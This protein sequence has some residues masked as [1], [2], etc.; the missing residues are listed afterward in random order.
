MVDS[1]E[2]VSGQSMDIEN[3]D[4]EKFRAAF[5]Q[6][7]SEGKIDI[8][9]LLALFGQYDDNDFE[10]YKFEW[11]G[12][13]ECYRI[14][15]KRSTGTIRPY[16]NESVNFDTT[17]N[18]YIEGDNLEVLK[19]LQASY[20]RKVKM[21]YIDPPY[22][23]GNDFVYEDDF[24][25]PMAKY[26]EVTQQTTKSNPETMGR[27]HTNWLNMM[28]PRLRLA[29]NLLR[30]D[31]VIFISIDETE[32]HNLKKICDE[33]FGEENFIADFVWHNKRGG[34]ND[35][36]FVAVEHE[37]VILYAKNVNELSELFVPYSPQYMLRYKE[38]DE[39][40]KFFWDTFKRKSGKQYYPITCPDGTVLQYDELG[41][42][43]SWLRS[44]PR[45]KEDLAKGEIRI[46]K[47]K[48]NW[49]V[50]FKQRLPE[51]K[52]PRTIFLEESI[53]EKQGTTADGSA[54]TLELFCKNVF[55]NPKPIGLIKH[56]LSFNTEDDDIIID[57][58][59]GSG[60]TAHAVMQL[61]SE[62]NQNRRFILVQLPA[63]I[64][65]DNKNS[66][67]AQT[68]Y[69]FLVEQGMKNNLCEIS[70]ERIRRA[71]TNIHEQNDSVDTGF[72]VFKLDTSNLVKW[73]STPTEDA[74]EL[75]QRMALLKETIKPDRN[76]LDMVY[77]TMLKLGIPLDY[78]VTEVEVNDKKAYSIGEDCLVLICLDYG[79]D[80]ITAEDIKTMCDDYVP[81]K[82]VASEQ[83]FKD[84]VA[85]SNA[86]Y[87]LKDRQI[88]MKLL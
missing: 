32:L 14:A 88:E 68:A 52:K 72:K 17:K 45:F 15:G 40:G 43:I 58:F 70:K 63:L 76:D 71:G 30:D 66:K 6:C 74:E 7:F 53:F 62:D 3:A 51:G 60:T 55:D 85:L 18:M 47:I 12:K 86:H 31:G 87:I 42:P 57:F 34:G 13:S 20:Y 59:A 26:K 19:L 44:E 67:T 64:E 23:T 77:E 41:N 16:P 61:N 8:S 24:S 48:D 73:D 39:L 80:G 69:E 36:K 25:D 29:A 28:Y 1:I 5:P 10:K 4:L 56:I 38:E 37:Y 2:R 83:A 33:V 65:P 82:I 35:A 54:E 81:A 79:K 84:D 49:S 50:Q 75:T 78:K 9:K 27:Y 46:V 11:K 21:I 22:N